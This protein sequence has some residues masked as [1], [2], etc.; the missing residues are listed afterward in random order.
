MT[1]VLFDFIA[2]LI[3]AWGCRGL[4]SVWLYFFALYLSIYSP[5]AYLYIDEAHSTGAVGPR[6]R[7]VCDLLDVDPADVDCLMGSFA[8]C[9]AANGGYIAASKVCL[10][11]CMC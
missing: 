10:R 2:G 1:E 5:Q 3:K 7:G 8:K 4:P 6:G 9:F 11:A